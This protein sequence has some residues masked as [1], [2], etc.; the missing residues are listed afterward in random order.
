MNRLT[1][2]SGIH[3]ILL[4]SAAVAQD[5]IPA[6]VPPFVKPAPA[7]DA[8]VLRL[9][10]PPK[11]ASSQAAP[12]LIQREAT[13]SRDVVRY[14]DSLSD[15]SKVE[16]WILGGKRIV[17]DPQTHSVSVMDPDHDPVAVVY[18]IYDPANVDWI[19]ADKYVGVEKGEAGS[20]YVF[21]LN[22]SSGS[23]ASPYVQSDY[24]L[25][26]G[27]RAW[28]DVQSG[29]LAQCSVNKRIY[30]IEY[31]QAPTGDL[32]LPE[33]FA[34]VWQKFQADRNPLKIERP[35]RD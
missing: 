29:R 3:L 6:P 19:T 12:E 20:F 33:A 22:G 1:L 23:G 34:R 32:V 27:R 9:K 25:P 11:G 26:S 13:R 15:G 8:Y 35:P 21:D 18:K 2:L 14:V 30:T 4:G 17:E 7:F 31:T 5:S 24:L 16:T 28:V 10:D